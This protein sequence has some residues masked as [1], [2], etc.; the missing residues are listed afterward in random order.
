[1]EVQG[2][3][4]PSAHQ[5]HSAIISL[6]ESIQKPLERVFI[7]QKLPIILQMGRFH[8]RLIKGKSA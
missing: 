3:Q 4:K 2:Q 6:L 5:K 7:S 8:T 1:M